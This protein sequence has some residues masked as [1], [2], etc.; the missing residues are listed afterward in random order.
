MREGRLLSDVQWQQYESARIDAQARVEDARRERLDAERELADAR[1]A[2]AAQPAREAG[3]RNRIERE[4]AGI[5]Q[6][7]PAAVLAE[8]RQAAAQARHFAQR[9]DFIEHEP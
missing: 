7:A 5:A 1:A 9:I 8:L 3:R 6:D 4:L 2:A